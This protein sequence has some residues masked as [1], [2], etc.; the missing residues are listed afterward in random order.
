M[1]CAT[2]EMAARLRGALGPWAVSGAA[3]EIGARAY[4]D[5]EWLM[6][7]AAR[8]EKDG[9]RLDVVLRDAGFEILGGTPLFRLARHAEAREIF[10]RLGAAAF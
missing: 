6:Q 4:A 1:P 10:A 2:P 7:S 5:R 9:A 8:L 3:V